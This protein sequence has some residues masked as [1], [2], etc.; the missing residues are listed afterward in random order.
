VIEDHLF[1]ALAILVF[2]VLPFGLASAGLAIAV[3]CRALLWRVLGYLLAVGG[4]WVAVVAGV[5]VAECPSQDGELCGEGA[6]MSGDSRE[7]LLGVLAFTCLMAIG[8]WR[9]A[10]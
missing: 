3:R 8:S 4:T 2:I 5:Y 10:A 9:R 6:G 1:D 7:L